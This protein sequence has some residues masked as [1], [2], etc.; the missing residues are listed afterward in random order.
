[1]AKGV[2]IFEDTFRHQMNQDGSM[3]TQDNLFKKKFGNGE[4]EWPVEKDKYRL[5]WMP[6][7]PHAHKVVITRNLLGLDN[8]ISLGT[9]GIFRYKDGWVFSEDPDEKDPV[10]GIHYLK[11]IYKREK[12]DF[13]ERPTVPIIVDEIS[14]KGVNNDHFWIP[15]YFETAWK[16]FHKKN[17][18]ELY[19]KNLRKDIDELNWF[20]FKRI[21][22]GVYNL[23]F[24]RS[25]EA[26]EK[27]YDLLFEALDYLEERLE[28]NRFLFGDFVTDSDIRLYPTLARFDVV[29]NTV[30]RANRNRIAD[31]INL[32]GYARDLY[33]IPEFKESTCFDTYKIHY[34]LSPHL[35][36][37]W[38]NVHGL[39][40][41]GPDTS[42]WE[43]EPA[44]KHLS[45]IP[46][47]KFLCI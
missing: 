31:Y 17:A 38:G 14:G 3:K 42:N 47:Q 29:Y 8:V 1:M 45:S 28:K 25:Q 15:N 12:A 20:I 26:Y 21:N 16:Q 18:P 33:Q 5:I 7:C 23:G 36:P 22:N 37:L 24:A 35:R 13:S 41:K 44:R 6:A 4:Y 39:V 43:K 11:D 34:Q 19:P 9:T 46:E 30:F 10:L 32:W 40:A 27:G 2:K